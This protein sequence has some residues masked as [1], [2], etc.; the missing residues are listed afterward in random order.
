MRLFDFNYIKFDIKAILYDTDSD[1][2]NVIFYLIMVKCVAAFD[3]PK[4]I[5]SLYHFPNL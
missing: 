3:C 5:F 4:R 1:Q 2:K